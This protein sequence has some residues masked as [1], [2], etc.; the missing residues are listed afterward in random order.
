MLILLYYLRNWLAFGA[1]I[2]FIVRRPEGFAEILFAIIIIFG[3]IP[4]GF[5]AKHEV[6]SRRY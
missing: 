4:L 6:E 5:W 3:F 1:M 2:Y